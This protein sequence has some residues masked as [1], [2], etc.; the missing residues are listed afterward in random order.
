V[1]GDFDAASDA[2]DD[3][4]AFWIGGL[5]V[6]VGAAVFFLF[7]GRGESFESAEHLALGAAVPA[8]A[9]ALALR[10]PS[11]ASRRARAGLI[12]LFAAF[13]AFYL[14]RIV[15]RFEWEAWAAAAFVAG[16]VR[17]SAASS[18]RTSAAAFLAAGLGFTCA[19]RLF[20]WEGTWRAFAARNPLVW[21]LLPGFTA[22]G[23]EAFLRGEK[24]TAPIKAGI[25]DAPALLLFALSST[26]VA[27]DTLSFLSGTLALLRRGA[28]LLWDAPSQYGFLN[29]ALTALVPASSAWQ[30]LYR[31]NSLLLFISALAV[32]AA[33]RL[34]TR[35]KWG[36][37]FSALLAESAVLLVPGRIDILDGPN[38]L[39]S[40]GAFRFLW[41][42]VLLAWAAALFARRRAGRRLGLRELAP[43]VV[44]W[45]LGCLWSAESAAYSCAA[46]WP[47]LALAAYQLARE[48]RLKEAAAVAAAPAVALAAGVAAVELFY[49]LR[50]GHGP[51][52]F[53]FVE[54]ALA[55]QGG[56]G[57]L[58]IWPRG[59]VAVLVW[60]GILIVA[61]AAVSFR[62]SA[63]AKWIVVPAF[64]TFW[65]T[66]SYFVSRSH[67]NNVLNLAPIWLS[68]LLLSFL[69]V[70]ERRPAVRVLRAGALP[71]LVGLL[72]A[73]FSDATRLRTYA[74]S[75][76]ASRA[77]AELDLAFVLPGH[78]IETLLARAG[79]RDDDPVTVFWARLL[80]RPIGPARTPALQPVWL[81]VA[82]AAELG[83]L[84]LKR[85]RLYVR[86]FL[87]R[88]GPAAAEGW[89]LEPKL[90]D[91]P[92][93]ESLPVVPVDLDR[94]PNPRASGLYAELLRDHRVDRTFESKNWRLV[95]FRFG[96]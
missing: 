54:Y 21:A 91:S 17:R 14:A 45:T 13:A 48:R 6:A 29:M 11:A 39:P 4:A 23:L 36:I 89:S 32:Y 52:W 67:D 35:G 59:A 73:A 15:P 82:P 60:A 44:F 90:F 62:R 16:W 24:K 84:D 78:E 95:H 7:P 37:V 27:A 92:E 55:Y 65:A 93:F 88:E 34:S 10:R 96:R 63:A 19:F 50:L 38:S 71:L 8:L 57:A 66:A 43:G 20:W 70:D 83:L 87:D 33:L 86:R 49:R 64:A 40:V 3:G 94:L 46:A 69:A 1:S 31:A 25:W 68:T 76:L 2:G 9:C 28:W 22:L 47:V 53:C 61:L 41:C 58:P 77:P 75:L 30:A 81:P 26:R 72:L 80:V 79:V 51:D 74:A 85:Q 5:G 42:Y 56:F 12:G 18:W